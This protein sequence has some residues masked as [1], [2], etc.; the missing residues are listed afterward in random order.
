VPCRV[1]ESI[2]GLT[3]STAGNGKQN[4]STQLNK[5]YTQL[6]KR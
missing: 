1:I 5:V 3:Y 6:G 4:V 2:G